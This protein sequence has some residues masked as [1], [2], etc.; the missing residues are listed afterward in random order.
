ME[1]EMRPP[2]TVEEMDETKMSNK[3]EVGGHAEE[4]M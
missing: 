3:Q 2:P 1:A 4:G